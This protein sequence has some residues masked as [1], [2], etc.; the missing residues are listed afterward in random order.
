MVFDATEE[1]A[2][3]GALF[4]TNLM[5][6]RLQRGVGCH[7]VD[8]AQIVQFGNCVYFSSINKKFHGVCP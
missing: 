1:Q 5:M 7:P 2:F 6:K 4:T 8:H 3:M